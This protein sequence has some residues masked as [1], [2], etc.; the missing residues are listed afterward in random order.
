MIRLSED[1]AICYLPLTV[2]RRSCGTLAEWLRRR[3]A[4]ALGYA[5]ESSNLSGVVLSEYFLSRGIR[6]GCGSDRS[7]IT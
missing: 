6:R 7:M 3:P 5:R 1:K 2:D 4:K